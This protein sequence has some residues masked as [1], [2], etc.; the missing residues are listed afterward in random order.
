[1]PRSP[2]FGLRLLAGAAFL[3]S[4][5]LVAADPLSRK[6]EID[7]YRDVLSREMHGLATRSDGRL[8]AGP[9]LT[10]LKGS[11]PSEL[12]WCLEP[13]GAGKWLIGTGP[14]GKI[15]EVTVSEDGT[16]F[17]SKEVAKLGEPQVYALKILPDGSILAGTSASGGLYLVR[18]G[19]IAARVGL[20][21]ESV[22]DLVLVDGGKAALA[23]TGNPGRIY[24]I[25]LARFANAG[26][27]PGRIADAKALTAKGVSLFGEAGDRNLRRMVRLSDG[28]IVVGSA[29]KG[30]IYLFPAQG[31]VPYIAQENHD[32]EVTDLL[33]DDKGGY[34]AAIVFS[35]GEIH[36]V[37]TNIQVSGT[38]EITITST[39]TNGNPNP[40]PTPTPNLHPNEN[41][42]EILNAPIQAERFPGRSSLQWFSPEGFPETLLSRS[43]VAFYRMGRTG[44]TLII[45]GGEQGEIAGY[46]LTERLSLTFAGSGSSQVNALESVP[47]NPT[48]FFAIRNN[49]P[50]FSIIDFGAASPRTAQTKRVDLGS[51]GRLGALRFNRLRDVDP[52]QLSISI[53]TTNAAN[54]TDGWSPWIPM[55]NADGWRA[56]AP[57]GRYFELKISLP[58]ATKPTLELD[59]ASIFYIG[60]NHRPQL[61]DF[62]MLSPNFAIV[63]PPEMPAPVVTTVGQLI[64]SGDRDG[65]RHRSGFMGSQI[66]ASPGTRVAFWTVNDPDGDNLLYTFSIRRDGDPKWTDIAIDSKE[67]YVQFETLQLQ[68]GTWFTRLE[69]KETAPRAESERLSVTFETDDMVVDHTPPEIEEATVRREAGKVIVTVRGKDALSLL[70]SAEFD[71]N[72]GVH[73]SV[74]QPVDGILD[75]KEESFLLELPAERLAGATSVEVTLYDSAGNGSTRRLGL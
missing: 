37:A 29:P 72:N 69:A 62:R 55:A 9:A 56:D 1:M 40:A 22:F 13:A 3:A 49:A 24:R 25:D 28:R 19:K 61:A 43:G 44:N 6:T 51:Q 57:T 36:P 27:S 23:S 15:F 26:V 31:G 59:R 73:E 5:V 48:R 14:G 2:F 66:V 20:P 58:A 32:A 41:P 21:A 35:G 70:D 45:S 42:A 67:S 50:G 16:A 34:Y 63:V 47:G 68:E 71:F 33:P 65:E 60:Q 54:E 74:E 12:L 10:D 38:T 39:S 75:G 46:D 17:T 64:Q 7:F 30:N 8:V 4:A 11:S 53:R 52:A 18:G